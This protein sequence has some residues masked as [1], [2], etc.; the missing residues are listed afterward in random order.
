M[1]E[2][3]KPLSMGKIIGLVVLGVLIVIALWF[4]GSYN[5]LVSLQVTVDEK[6]SNVE[7][8]YQR[9]FDLIP[10]LEAAVKGIF[11]Q[12]QE[13]FKAIADARTRYANAE[14]GTPEKLDAIRQY[15]S[16]L[17]RLLVIV[18]N[19]PNLRS[20]DQVQTFM[21]QIEGTENR[22]K[23]ARNEYNA[24]VTSY[25]KKVQ[26]FPSNIVAG[27]FGFTQRAFFQ[28]TEE[29]KMTVPKV[30]LITQ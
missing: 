12:E 24:A 13:V 2:T 6:Q 23:V 15:D 10:N 9:R 17:A 30:D 11:N 14:K 19:Y 25:N 1:T 8:D 16:A 3:R 28:A 29:A 21:V 27:M 7:A 26:I 22:I 5:S 4:M 20:A 18:E